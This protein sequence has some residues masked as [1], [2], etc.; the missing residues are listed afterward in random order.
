MTR[1]F[2]FDVSFSRG[3]HNEER[4][5]AEK[6]HTALFRLGER[7]ERKN[8]GSSINRYGNQYVS[9]TLKSVLKKVN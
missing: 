4:I 5:E 7:I 9:V 2:V 3:N 8:T 6:Y 1:V